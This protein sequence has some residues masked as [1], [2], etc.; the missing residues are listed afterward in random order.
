MPRRNTTSAAHPI[1]AANNAE[2]EKDI[3]SPVSPTPKILC[4]NMFTI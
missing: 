1:A 2:I 4:L 3:K